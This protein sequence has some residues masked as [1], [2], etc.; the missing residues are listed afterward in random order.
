MAKVKF[1]RIRKWAEAN[2]FEVKE[3][4]REEAITVRVDSTLYFSID[5][6]ASAMFYGRNGLTGDRGGLY[7]SIN[8]EGQRW[9]GSC[10]YYSQKEMIEYME[11]F[12][13][14]KK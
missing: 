14:L 12:T 8:K 13:G 2:G 5:N 11:Q 7:M 9:S 6:R 10:F 1:T 4:Y 3:G